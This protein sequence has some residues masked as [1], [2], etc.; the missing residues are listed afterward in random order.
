MQ[1][2]RNILCHFKLVELSGT[3]CKLDIKGVKNMISRNLRELRER[4]KYTQEE[5]AEKIGVSRQAVAK[6]EN[7]KTVPNIN[8]C[9]ALAELYE[10]NLDALVGYSDDEKKK[11]IQPKGKHM[12]GIVKVGERGQIVIPKKAREVFN[13]NA[14]D[15]LL[16]MG[17]ESQGIGI[18]KS[19]EFLQFAQEIFDAQK[20]FDDQEIF[21]APEFQEED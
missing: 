14:G 5:I 18:I 6:W 12:F 13:I 9:V 20:I 15:G 17:D 21:D 7:G 1:L 16:I 11:G 2:Q 4:H 10:V 8:N 19:E 3:Y